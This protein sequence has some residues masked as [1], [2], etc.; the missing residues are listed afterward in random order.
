MPTH[1]H[2]TLAC[3]I[4]SFHAAWRLKYSIYTDGS[5]ITVKPTLGASIVD[6]ATHTTTRME[7]KSQSERH[8]INR[9]VLMAITL[10]LEVNK[11]NP[12]LSISIDSAFSI[13]T[14]RTYAIDSLSL[15]RQPHTDLLKLA[16]DSNRTRDTL[17]EQ[18]A[19]IGKVK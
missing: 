16:D 14:L 1:L 11:E 18:K 19:H 17:V 5:Q 12:T 6:P 13:N 10:A 8:T 7:I 4:S 15:I 9:A 3:R 2:T